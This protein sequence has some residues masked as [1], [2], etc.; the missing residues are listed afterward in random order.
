MRKRIGEKHEL[1]H[2]EMYADN[3]IHPSAII[4]ECVELGKGNWIGPFAIIGG[5]GEIRNQEQFSGKIK[6]G[7][8]NVIS[9]GVTIDQS[10]KGE[11]RI[12]S[13]CF[14]M[15]KAH[16]GHDVVIKDF[17][18]I[19][20]GVVIG[21]HV[22]INSH[23]QVGLNSTIRPRVY[24]EHTTRI[25]MGSIV[26]K[27]ITEAEWIHLGVPAGKFNPNT[28]GVLLRQERERRAAIKKKDR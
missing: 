25:G 17:V 14:I 6:I 11:T 21:G 5:P 20:T 28:N 24:I 8:N 23:C 10:I 26:T 15:A 1:T 16:I 12:G 18:E 7:D 2:P 19:S 13:N 27:S 3:Y 4:D 9:G 22:V